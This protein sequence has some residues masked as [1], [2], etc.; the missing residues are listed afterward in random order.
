MTARR[1]Y[2]SDVSD[3]EWAFVAP[4]LTLMKEDAPQR[5]YPLR[6]VF[7]GLRYIVRTGAQW[8]M[9]PNDLP[10]WP[11]VYQQTQRWLKAGVFE[12]M[13][14]DLR[15]LIRELSERMPQPRAAI[16]DSRTLQSSP[17]SGA[18]AGYDG[19]KRRKGSK[20]HLAVD[21]L[22]QLLAVHVTPANE[23]DRA[24]VAALAEQIQEG[25]GESVEVAFVDQGYTGD[26]PAADA[27]AHGIRLEVVKLPTAK[28][29]FVLLPRRWVV[30]RSFAWMARFRRLARDYERLA[31]TLAGLHFVAFAI[32]LAHR[33]ITFMVQSA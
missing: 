6:E 15:T 24:Q 11:V 21:T 32:L 14:R 2:P 23:Q 29:G 28:H 17:E 33:F 18:R 10:P 13:V 26:Q 30:E 20:V 31:D 12:D 22:G 7:N 9:M 4:Y 5:E 3:D 27:E 25:T 8:R 1:S 19:H 16:L